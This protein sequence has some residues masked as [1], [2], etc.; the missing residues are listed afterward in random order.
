MLTER[1]TGINLVLPLFSLYPHAVSHFPLLKS[2]G[3]VIAEADSRGKWQQQSVEAWTV[4]VPSPTH[5]PIFSDQIPCQSTANYLGPRVVSK[6]VFKKMEKKMV[7]CAA[8]KNQ[9]HERGRGEGGEKEKPLWNRKV[10]F[11]RPNSEGMQGRSSLPRAV[12]FRAAEADVC[13]AKTESSRQIKKK[14]TPHF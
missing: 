4:F 11:A 2:H 5:L 12:V 1:R 8:S 7:G 14:K 13:E 10:E 9:L 3:Q 6:E